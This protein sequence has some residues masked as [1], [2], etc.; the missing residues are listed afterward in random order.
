MMSSAGPAQAT[1]ESGGLVFHLD[2]HLVA[3]QGCEQ[4][5]DSA[6]GRDVPYERWIGHARAKFVEDDAFEDVGGLRNCPPVVDGGRVHGEY[7][8]QR[9]DGGVRAGLV[10]GVPVLNPALS[11]TGCS[12]V[13]EWFTMPGSCR[14]AHFAEC[15]S[16]TTCW[17]RELR[18]L[19][20]RAS[21]AAVR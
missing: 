10:L 4:R 5:I 6:V 7:R 14:S 2:R 15:V 1:S 17:G 9:R 12:G 13:A 18:E 20:A 16:R 11:G 19:N 21:A 8:V 3:V